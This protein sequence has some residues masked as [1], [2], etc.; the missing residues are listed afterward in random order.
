MSNTPSDMIKVVVHDM[1][2]CLIVP[3]QEELSVDDAKRVQE[4]L[5]DKLGARHVKGVVIDF[6][7]VDIVDSS[8]WDVF[9]KLVNM[10]KVMG[11]RTAITGLSP[12]IIAS[13]I[14][15]NMDIGG[16]TTKRN[17]EEALE[18]LRSY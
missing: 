4:V 18:Y 12:G 9:I 11:S 3:I 5:L 6:S 14:D 10:V 15:S 7:G 8:L 1:S 13:M 2:R 16:L 17:M